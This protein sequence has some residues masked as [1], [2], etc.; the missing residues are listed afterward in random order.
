M[1][2][3]GFPAAYA[4]EIMGFISV[5]ATYSTEGIRTEYTS[6]DSL[7]AEIAAPGSDSYKSRDSFV[8]P[9]EYG[10]GL[11]LLSLGPHL[12]MPYL[13]MHGTSS[14]APVVA[15]AAAYL[16]A[17]YKARGIPYTPQMVE[18]DLRFGADQYMSLGGTSN[19]CRSLNLAGSITK[20]LN[21]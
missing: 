5:A 20:A 16:I 2:R 10:L 12:L 8:S 14:A 6:G 15:G 3:V 17:T 4:T 9:Y 1:G 21:R 18:E 19:G 13:R 7:L 11:G